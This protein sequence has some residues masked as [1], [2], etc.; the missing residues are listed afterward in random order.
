[1]IMQM[2][3]NF[4]TNLV[5]L[6]IYRDQTMCYSEFCGYMGETAYSIYCNQ[7]TASTFEAVMSWHRNSRTDFNMD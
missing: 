1:M 3:V 4:C 7:T 5:G 6:L 2:L